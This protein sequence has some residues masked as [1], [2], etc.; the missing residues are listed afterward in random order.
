MEVSMLALPLAEGT[1]LRTLEPWHA[2]EFLAPVDR[3]REHLRPWL[4]WSTMFVDLPSA[5]AYLQS[6]ADKQAAD[7]GRLY[8]I[9][10]DGV[11]IGGTLFRT[12]DATMGV[13]EVGVWL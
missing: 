1:E 2:A 5:Q 3:A 13:C 12:F 9:W 11:L 4:P 10:A 6:Y 8:G 7:E